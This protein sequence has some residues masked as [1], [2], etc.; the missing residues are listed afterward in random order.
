MVILLMPMVSIVLQIPLGIA[1]KVL[2][3]SGTT[4]AFFTLVWR[5]EKDFPNVQNLQS[6]Q[7]LRKGLSFL[8][9]VREIVLILGSEERHINYVCSICCPKLGLFWLVRKDHGL[10]IQFLYAKKQMLILTHY[11]WHWHIQILIWA[12]SCHPTQPAR[13][14]WFLSKLGK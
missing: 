14:L 7:E 6:S 8:F 13:T 10:D 1:P 3:T 12:F 5:W 11:P 2:I 4:F 9:R